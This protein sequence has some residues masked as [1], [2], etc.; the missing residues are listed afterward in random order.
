MPD[1]RLARRELAM[2][3]DAREGPIFIGWDV[4]ITLA[5]ATHVR[6]CRAGNRYYVERQPLHGNQPP[7]TE[8]LSEPDARRLFA[9]LRM[10]M[11]REDIAF[12][13]SSE[14]DSCA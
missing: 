2:A 1:P 13:R 5:Q 11:V 7:V 3:L 12:P 4:V 8:D 14:G 6:L 9:G 10:K